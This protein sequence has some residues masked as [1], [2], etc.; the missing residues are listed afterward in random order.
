[1]TKEISV[2]NFLSLQNHFFEDSYPLEIL[3]RK[4]SVE[5]FLSSQKHLLENSYPLKMFG[6]QIFSLKK[7][8]PRG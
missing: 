7:K 2:E 3:T 5:H 1:M 6:R 4:F 8:I